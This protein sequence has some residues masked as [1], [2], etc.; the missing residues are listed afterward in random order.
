MSIDSI[1]ALGLAGIQKGLQGA[2]DS[3]AEIARAGQTGD[4]GDLTAALVS[5]RAGEQQVAA[6]SKVLKGADEMLGTLI[7]DLA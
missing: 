1:T 7:D 2:R 3:A 5:L 4:V 6:A